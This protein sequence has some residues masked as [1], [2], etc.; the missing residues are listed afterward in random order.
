MNR[1]ELLLGSVAV[2]ATKGVSPIEAPKT[3][4]WKIVPEGAYTPK[5]PMTMVFDE[6]AKV[7]VENW[8]WVDLE[9]GETFKVYLHRMTPNADE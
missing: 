2:L 9:E 3:G 8:N 7:L 1:R 6:F 4:L 5:G